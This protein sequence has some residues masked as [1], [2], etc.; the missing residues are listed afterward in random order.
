MAGKSGVEMRLA[1]HEAPSEE[2]GSLAAPLS[3]RTEIELR[4]QPPHVLRSLAS[5]LF[6]VFR[7]IVYVHT[8]CVRKKVCL[9]ASRWG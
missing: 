1:K 3:K 2:E 6:C 9:P 4:D 5:R 7:S 8:R